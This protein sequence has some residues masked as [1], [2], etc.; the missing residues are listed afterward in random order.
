MPIPEVARALLLFGLAG[1]AEIGGGW[2]V[3]QFLRSD[4]PWP[5]GALGAVVLMARA[6]T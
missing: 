2:L 6:A 1:L 3:W 4:R 5:Y